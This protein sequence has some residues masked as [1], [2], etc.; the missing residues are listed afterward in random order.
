MLNFESLKNLADGLKSDVAGMRRTIDALNAKIEKFESDKTRSQAYV[1]ENI[2]AARAEMLPALQKALATNRPRTAAIFA[3]REGYVQ[4]GR[5]A[6][7]GAPDE[8]RAAYGSAYVDA[9][10]V[11]ILTRPRLREA[12]EDPLSLL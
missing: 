7:G 12:Q 3:D 6:R 9:S 5:T 1:A 11:R 10:L 8:P 4:K 2:K